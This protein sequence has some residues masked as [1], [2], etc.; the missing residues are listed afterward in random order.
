LKTA[1]NLQVERG[2]TGAVDATKRPTAPETAI[3]RENGKKERESLKGK[4]GFEHERIL[5]KRTRSARGKKQ[6]DG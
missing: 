2:E 5:V 4:M 6:G 3:K 1:K